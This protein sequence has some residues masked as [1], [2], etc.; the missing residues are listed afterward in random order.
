VLFRSKKLFNTDDGCVGRSILTVDRSLPVQEIINKACSGDRGETTVSMKDG[1]YQFLASPVSASGQTEGVVLLAF[2]VTEKHRAEELRREFS[3]NVTHELK[4][5]LQS[6]MGSAE[7]LE[8]GIVEN[9]D[10][11]RFVGRIRSEAARLTVL[12]DDI[13][14][15]S[16]LDEQKNMPRE[17]VDLYQLSQDIADNLEHLAESKNVTVR[18]GGESAVLRGVYQALWELVYNLIDNAIKYNHENGSVDVTVE[19]DDKEIRLTVSDT[20][21][22]IPEAHQNRVFERFYRV[23][24]SHSKETGGTGLGLSIVK[25]AAKY[26]NASI[27][28]ESKEGEG[29]KITVTFPK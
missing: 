9:Q 26:H 7:L 23:D 4:T 22:G 29:T 16:R 15:L 25:H 3:A 6:I 20:G 5:P 12:I 19:E 21:I 1:T 28:L 14:M 2:D 10:I 18:V 27:E 24:K 17:D 11:P 8:S 13:L